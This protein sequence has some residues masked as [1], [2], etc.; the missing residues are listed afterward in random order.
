LAKH[1]IVLTATPKTWRPETALSTKRR[2][3]RGLD[4]APP[5]SSAE[6]FPL[7]GHFN[8]CRFASPHPGEHLG[9]NGLRRNH[10]AEVIPYTQRENYV[11]LLKT[12]RPQWAVIGH[13]GHAYRR[14]LED[15]WF[16]PAAMSWST[17]IRRS[18]QLLEHRG[19]ATGHNLYL[20]VRHLSFDSLIEL[21]LVPTSIRQSFFKLSM[22]C[23][24]A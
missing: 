1:R 14:I 17:A 11:G 15:P 13:Y 24:A 9:S 20:G 18:S 22:A 19:P 2:I 5:R 7:A 6:P 3:R 16:S 21:T 23:L 10:S 8:P 4:R 12:W